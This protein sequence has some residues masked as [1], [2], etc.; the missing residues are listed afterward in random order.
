MSRCPLDRCLVDLGSGSVDVGSLGSGGDGFAAHARQQGGA[1]LADL[2]A[3]SGW[4]G[5]LQQGSQGP[6]VGLIK[7]LGVG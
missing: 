2:A 5:D 1:E 6:G 4:V 7:C 3:G